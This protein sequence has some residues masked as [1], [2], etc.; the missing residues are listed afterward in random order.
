MNIVGLK[1]KFMG[2]LSRK[3]KK[4]YFRPKMPSDWEKIVENGYTLDIENVLNQYEKKY[5]N[6]YLLKQSHWILTKN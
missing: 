2:K 4:K 3:L 1:Q 5:K 6:F